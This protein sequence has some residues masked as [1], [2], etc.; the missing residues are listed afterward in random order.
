MGSLFDKINRHPCVVI[1]PWPILWKRIVSLSSFSMS[2]LSK[3]LTIVNSF[4]S[5]A[6]TFL[7]IARK[8]N[9]YKYDTIIV[10]IIVNYFWW[11]N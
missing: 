4:S 6:K 2:L 10:I 3:L 1:I 8:R 5:L 9:G 7:P 11:E